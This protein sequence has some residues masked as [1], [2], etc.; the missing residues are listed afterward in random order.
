MHTTTQK[1]LTQQ[2]KY[3]KFQYFQK[4]V[5]KNLTA[6]LIVLLFVLPS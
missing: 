3:Y 6:R 4:Y 5:L 2:N 1:I